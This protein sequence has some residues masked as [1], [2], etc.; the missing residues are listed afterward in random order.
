MIEGTPVM[1]D[2]VRVM[3]KGVE[4]FKSINWLLLVCRIPIAGILFVPAFYLA[5]ESKKQREKEN[6]Y[7][8]LEIKMASIAPYFLG[9]G[10]Q[11]A[12]DIQKAKIDLAQKLL[13]PIEEKQD[14]HVVIPP[15]V[16][17]LIK[18]LVNIK[19]KG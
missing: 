1:V 9:V 10:D 3:I 8:E 19:S 4:A 16:L 2:G 13:S 11:K 6:R 14:N 7:R 5:N 12:A 17:E 15:D 18:L